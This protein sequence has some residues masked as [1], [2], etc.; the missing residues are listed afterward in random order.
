VPL[1]AAARQSQDKFEFFSSALRCLQSS[2]PQPWLYLN[3]FSFRNSF[4]VAR[5]SSI[6]TICLFP[7]APPLNHPADARTGNIKQQPALL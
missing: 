2:S 5:K 6:F 1:P 7:G 3:L 4:G